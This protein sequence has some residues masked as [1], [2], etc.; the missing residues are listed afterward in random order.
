MLSKVVRRQPREIE[1]GSFL[2]FHMPPPTP[3]PNAFCK[4]IEN[5]ITKRLEYKSESFKFTFILSVTV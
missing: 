5:L 3:P 1:I 2:F 4:I